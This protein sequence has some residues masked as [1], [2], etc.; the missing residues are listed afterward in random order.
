MQTTIKRTPVRKAATAGKKVATDPGWQPVFS[1][2]EEVRAYFNEFTNAVAADM[3]IIEAA[4]RRS[5][6]L[7]MRG[8]A[9]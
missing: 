1:S 9:D 4:R 3:R 5:E 8:F 6:E 7:V 2:D